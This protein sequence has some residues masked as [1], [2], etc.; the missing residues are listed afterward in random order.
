ME[1]KMKLVLLASVFGLIYMASIA[2]GLFQEKELIDCL[3]PIWVYGIICGVS[4]ASFAITLA[5]K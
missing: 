4:L 2:L 1:K 5:Q 3:M